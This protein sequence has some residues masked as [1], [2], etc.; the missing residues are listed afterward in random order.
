[1]YFSIKNPCLKTNIPLVYQYIK[2]SPGNSTFSGLFVY[3]RYITITP[4]LPFVSTFSFLQK[5]V[6]YESP[7]PLTDMYI[8][9]NFAVDSPSQ[10]LPAPY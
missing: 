3:Y 5:V 9:Y 8:P 4:L 10:K 1:M 2:K 7:V 6:V